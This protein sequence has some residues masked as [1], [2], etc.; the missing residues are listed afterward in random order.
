MKPRLTLNDKTPLEI[1]AEITLNLNGER[2][3]SLSEYTSVT[4]LNPS[5]LIERSLLTI[6]QGMMSAVMQTLNSIYTA[7]YMQALS[8]SMD[9]G[10]INAVEI[11][12]PFSTDPM[13]NPRFNVS[14]SGESFD[15]QWTDE[16]LKLPD[17]S[18]E[19]LGKIEID[20]QITKPSNLAV[21]KLIHVPVK[22]PGGSTTI[23]VN[24]TLSPREA[25]ID[26]IVDLMT[27]L[28]RDRDL[29][30]RWHQVWAGEIRFFQDFIFNLD[31]LEAERKL[32]VRDEDGF[33]RESEARRAAGLVSTALTRK[34]QLNVASNMLCI[35]T[36]GSARL[37]LA[38][39][40][41]LS[42]Y[43]ARKHLFRETGSIII[44]VVDPMRER[45]KIYTRGVKETAF[46]TF[47]DIKQN[48]T[49][50][51]G[52]DINAVMKAYNMAG[53]G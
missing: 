38:I 48:A 28:S 50:P 15:K 1:G 23:P 36:T 9:I 20:A 49:N 22:G 34:R 31:I 53:R 27:N 44:C 42:D 30:A 12:Q 5:V 51:N 39:R 17:F 14:M 41:K 24:V 46:Y 21:G 2:P 32:A 18:G 16:S 43:R 10:G 33:Y 25:D 35:S 6:D 8:L 13:S 40:G 45:I 19:S 37:D 3:E 29:Q 26:F 11:L 4:R 7:H 47:D 52:I